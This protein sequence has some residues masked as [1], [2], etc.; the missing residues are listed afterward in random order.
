MKRPWQIW[1]LFLICLA[2]VLPVMVWLT[3]MALEL[4]RAEAFVQQQGDLEEAVGSVLW[5]MDAELTRLLAPEIARPSLFY[6]SFYTVPSGKGEAR[7]VP[8][9]L[10]MQPSPYVL[11]HFELRPDNIWNSPQCPQDELIDLAVAND[12]TSSNIR[13]SNDRLNE[14][15]GN[16]RYDHLLD[17]VPQQAL[18][19]DLLDQT[20]WASN[21]AFTQGSDQSQVMMNRLVDESVRQQ[22]ESAQVNQMPDFDA[23]SQQA[24]L[25]PNSSLS[26]LNQRVQSRRQNELQSRNAAL[27][28]AAQQAFRD[29]R[30]NF[31]APAELSS[32]IEGISQPVWIDSHL[33][34]VRRVESGGKTLIQG[35]WLDWDKIR[36]ELLDR[37]APLLPDADLEPVTDMSQMRF[38]RVLATLP[39]Q[40]IV[41]E[42]MAVIRSFSPIRVSLV[43]AWF[44]LLLAAAAMFV[45]LKAVIALSERRAAFV[46]A[47]THELRTPLTTFRMYAEM[48]SEG[49][50]TDAGQ[51]RTYLETLRIE[52]DRLSHLVENVLQYARL[53]RGSPGKRREEIS[54]DALLDR[55]GTRLAERAAQADMLLEIETNKETRTVVISTDPAAVEQI[56][57]NLVDNACK[58]A[59]AA[60]DRRI[61]LRLESQDRS[62]LISV[63]DHGPGVTAREAERLF[64]PFSKSAR[65]AANSAPGVGL[66][67]ALCRRLAVDLGGRLK[68]ECGSEGAAFVLVLPR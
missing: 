1:L 7:Q 13:V 65:E 41:P 38:T 14:L 53:E 50:I 25:L 24:A 10:L 61:H 68:V 51:Q 62:I 12:A 67:L 21:T 16:V 22:M 5:Q 3:H 35:C 27:Q 47:V 17:Q 29:Q 44:F 6:R 37:A 36:Q 52:A 42:P 31:N 33:L 54:L 45:L 20:Q 63:V 57:F 59:S 48:L 8:S 11:L 66:G 64:R 58:Y 2:M 28:A 18:E 19:T 43:V 60:R 4:D 30:S 40:L 39:A 34:L 9:P 23:Q 32:E 26:D 46:S 15:A 55:A 49:M 56:L